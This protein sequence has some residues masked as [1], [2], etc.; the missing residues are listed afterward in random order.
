MQ[1]VLDCVF[2][3]TTTACTRRCD[4]CTHAYIDIPPHFM[5]ES[6]FL[7]I[8]ADLGEMDFAGRLA[9]YLNGEP[10]LD[11]RLERWLRIA[12]TR[13]PKALHF[14]NTNGDLLT[15][16][17][18]ASLFAAGLD[19]MKVN[20]YT[21][22]AVERL[23]HLKGQ[24]PRDERH[25]ILHS[26]ATKI[27]DWSSRGGVVTTT[28]KRPRPYPDTLCPRPFRQL[29]ITVTGRVALCCTDDQ[30]SHPMGDLATQS[31]REIWAGPAFAAVRQG[32]HERDRVPALCYDCDLD[33]SY[34]NVEQVRALFAPACASGDT[35][36]P[37]LDHQG[38]QAGASAHL[39]PSLSLSST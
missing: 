31:V 19:A 39:Q 7:K 22:K 15:P 17:R 29:Y 20:S 26:D 23:E 12:K 6:L 13:C 32:F 38:R 30:C 33:P 37:D 8:I 21:G 36:T 11:T 3:E 10:L 5:H 4:F 24:L 25:K 34:S 2:I 16:E 18:A 35:S 1:P 14:I 28:P 9:F 27:T